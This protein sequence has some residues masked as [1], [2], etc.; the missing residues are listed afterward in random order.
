MTPKLDDFPGPTPEARAAQL[1]QGL[2]RDAY[3]D[4][5]HQD[6]VRNDWNH[7]SVVAARGN[8]EATVAE[9]LTLLGPDADCHLV[10]T[11]LWS[12]FS[13][14]HKDDVGFRPRSPRSRPA[15]LRWFENLKASS[16]HS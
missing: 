10:D 1:R 9:L 3:Y 4:S 2:A 11:D 5:F 15:V 7:P 14:A 6:G 8:Y 13:D 12:A 16:D